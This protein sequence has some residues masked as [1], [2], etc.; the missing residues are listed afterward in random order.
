VLKKGKAA[1]IGGAGM[2]VVG[3][4]GAG[5]R[6]RDSGSRPCFGRRSPYLVS[7]HGRIKTALDSADEHGFPDEHLDQLPLDPASPA[8][9][10]A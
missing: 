3:A 4:L 9:G 6:T 10:T 1:A 7:A 8:L 5:P 2:T